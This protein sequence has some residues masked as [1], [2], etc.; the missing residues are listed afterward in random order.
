MYRHEQLSLEQRALELYQGGRRTEAATLFRELVDRGCREATV[1]SFGGFLI[2]TEEGDVK[3]GLSWC[4]RA[5]EI[6]FCDVQMYIN[7]ARLHEQ[8]GWRSQ[9]AAVLRKGLRQE[10]GNPRLLAEINRVSPRTRDILPLLPREHV[11]NK[12][13]GKLRAELRGGSAPVKPKTSPSY[14]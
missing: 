10:P 1:L 9:A 7:L 8:T 2:A 12:A 6:A 4:E 13:V 5:V 3:T 14:S 11:V